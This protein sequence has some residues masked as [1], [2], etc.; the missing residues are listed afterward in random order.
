M[1]RSDDPPDW[2]SELEQI[3]KDHVGVVGWVLGALGCVSLLVI[4]LVIVPPLFV[5]PLFDLGWTSTLFGLGWPLVI[6]LALG[7]L[8]AFLSGRV[9]RTHRSEAR[10]IGSVA[11]AKLMAPAF[12]GLICG[13][14]SALL[15]G[16]SLLIFIGFSRLS[17]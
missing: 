9:L 12:A 11:S 14:L 6:E 15:A 3:L 16:F 1:L 13:I 4:V 2:D 10:R 17:G 7:V 8:V 5:P